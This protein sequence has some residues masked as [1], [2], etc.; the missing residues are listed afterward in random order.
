MDKPKVSI[1]VPVYNAEQYFECCLDSILSQ[2]FTEFEC[3][4]VDDRS[5]D[6]CPVLCDK[7]AKQDA[8]IKVIHKPQNEG[9]PLARKNG[10]D[11]AAGDYIQFVDSDDWIEKEMTDLLYAQAVKE[12]LD[13]VYCNWVYYDAESM[14]NITHPC[15][16]KELNKISMLKEWMTQKTGGWVIWNKLYARKLFDGIVFPNYQQLEDVVLVMQLF[17]KAERIGCEYSLLYHYNT[18]NENS[19]T[20]SANRIKTNAMERSANLN[21]LKSILIND[22]YYDTYRIEFDKLATRIQARNCFD[23]EHLNEQ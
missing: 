13:I 8:R 14:Q 19:L 12:N 17:L 6:N 23:M 21:L 10:L 22:G 1:I 18:N 16:E 15:S 2:T 11:N 4:L 20:R 9:V 7:Y 5:P 3:I